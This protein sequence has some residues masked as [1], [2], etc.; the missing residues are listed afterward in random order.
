MNEY[1]NPGQ[2]HIMWDAINHASGMYFVEMVI[3]PGDN[4]TIVKDVRKILYLK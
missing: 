4:A 3:R 2:Y 1:K